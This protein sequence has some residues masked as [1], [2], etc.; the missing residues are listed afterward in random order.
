MSNFADRS[1]DRDALGDRI[2]DLARRLRWRLFRFPRLTGTARYV[3]ENYG[4]VDDPDALR[5]ELREARIR[6]ADC[7]VEPR[8]LNRPPPR[9]D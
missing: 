5:R 2:I 8:T 4:E 1:D 3:A 9:D 7:S 6:P